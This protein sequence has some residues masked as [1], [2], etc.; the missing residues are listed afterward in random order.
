MTYIIYPKQAL[1][2]ILKLNPILGW[3]KPCIWEH[4]YS[5]HQ[6][7]QTRDLMAKIYYMVDRVVLNK[8]HSEINAILSQLLDGKISFSVDI[9]DRWWELKKHWNGWSISSTLASAKP[10]HYI[11]IEDTSI[12]DVDDW[13]HTQKITLEE[14][15]YSS[16]NWNYYMQRPTPQLSKVKD[17]Y[18]H[19][20][21][22][23]PM[24]L[25]MPTNVIKNQMTHNVK[26]LKVLWMVELSR[27]LDS[28][29]I[30]ED[31][32]L[33]ELLGERPRLTEEILSNFFGNPLKF[34]LSN[35]DK[36]WSL[37]EIKVAGSDTLLM[38]KLQENPY[39]IAQAFREVDLTGD[40]SA[41]EWIN[42]IRGIE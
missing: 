34:N 5:P 13:L 16:S 6:M 33:F 26:L 8:E 40:D 37:T 29:P 27:R 24:L 1:L 32:L 22:H 11:H 36:W 30:P 3:D 17:K 15:R 23:K 7:N 25:Y 4:N 14:Y 19:F 9:F 20:G 28:K 31:N 38:Q 2:D 42:Q 41:D 18:S 35:F 21:F 12:S 39:K 10:K